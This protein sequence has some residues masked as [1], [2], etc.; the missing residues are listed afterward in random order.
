MKKYINI[1][2]GFNMKTK[3]IIIASIVVVILSGLLFSFTFMNKQKDE[4]HKNTVQV[5]QEHKEKH[6]CC[7][8]EEGEEYSENSIY[9]L[10]SIWKDQNGN[11]FTLGDLEGKPVI[12]SMFFASCT[13]ACPI[14]VND[15]KKIEESLPSGE[16]GNYQFVL[17]SIDPERDTPEALK[18]FAQMKGLDLSRWTLLSGSKENI[19]ELAALT[20]FKYKKEPD[21]SFS[22]SN[23]IMLI[24][25]EG[26]IVHQHLGLNQDLTAA[27]NII[28]NL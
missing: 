21:G 13:Y 25:D 16:A 7:S 4:P 6:S 14:I 23:M 5:K 2:S 1:N 15:M 3:G 10:E 8:E 12:L 11:K 28:K 9:Q 24:N 18:K 22:H 17:V 20:G 27:E 19:Q 26:E